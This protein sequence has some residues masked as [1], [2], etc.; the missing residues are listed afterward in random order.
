MVCVP[1]PMLTP[2]A[3]EVLAAKLPAAAYVA[4]MLSVPGGSVV[5]LIVATP[6]AFNA[7]VPDGVAP[8]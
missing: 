6:L 4:V 8:L 5:V 7:P 2:L 3:A 1:W